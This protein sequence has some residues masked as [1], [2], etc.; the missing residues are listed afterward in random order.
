MTHDNLY[1]VSNGGVGSS[2]EQFAYL[3][4]NVLGYYILYLVLLFC[5]ILYLVFSFFRA[6]LS[7]LEYIHSFSY[8]L[9]KCDANIWMSGVM[10]VCILVCSAT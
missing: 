10:C 7:H 5:D 1:W 3:H 8:D 6:P 4:G 9:S 2:N